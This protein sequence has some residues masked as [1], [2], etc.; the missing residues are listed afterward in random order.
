M[1]LDMFCSFRD[2]KAGLGND[3]LYLYHGDRG[4]FEYVGA[5]L[6]GIQSNPYV[7]GMDYRNGR[8][9]V[10]WVY[11]GFVHYEGWDDPADTK[12]KQ[13]AGPNSAANNHNICYAYSDDKGYTWKN[14]QGQ[15]IADLR[16]GGSI[17][18]DALGIVA[19]GIPKNSGL[20]NQEAQA[21]D[22]DG[23]VHVLNRDTVD[24]EYLW[25]HY[26]RSP[27]GKFSR[28]YAALFVASR[29]TSD[30]CSIHDDSCECPLRRMADANGLGTWSQRPLQRINGSRR[31]RL[32]ISKHGNL[33][34]MLPDSLGPTVSISRATKDTRYSTFEHMWTGHGFSGEPLADITRLEHDNFL[35]LFMRADVDGAPAK[36]NAV[37]MDFKL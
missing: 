19:F 18:N 15:V 37:V 3:H 8:L 10:T 36:K 2:G 21:V 24:G 16:K 1:D 25:K 12:H 22:Q 5:H 32:A 33:Y 14:G 4:C 13:Q 11:R 7:H 35:S 29:L 20:M 23:G 27:D 28:L 30:I 31:G 6:T 17:T 9:H 26:Y 34:I